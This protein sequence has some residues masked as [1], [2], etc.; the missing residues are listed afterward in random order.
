MTSSSRV[1]IRAKLPTLRVT[2]DSVD[3][4]ARDWPGH[5]RAMLAVGCAASL[6]VRVQRLP[7]LAMEGQSPYDSWR[8]RTQLILS[9]VLVAVA[10][11][12]S[13]LEALATR[14]A[15]L[16]DAMQRRWPDAWS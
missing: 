1:R 12:A 8:R 10:A 5:G 13:R 7:L 2:P 4:R 9:R 3:R 11:A 14:I 15:D 16:A 6:A